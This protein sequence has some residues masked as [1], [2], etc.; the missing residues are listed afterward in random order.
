MMTWAS[1]RT[2]SK[3]CRT[4]TP[5]SEKIS[6]TSVVGPTSVTRAPSLVSA[7]TLE[8]ATRLK[9]MS[10]QI[11]TW[12]SFHLRLSPSRSRMVKASS[13]AW[14]GCSCAP[15]PALTMWALSR[16]AR[17]CG[18]PAAEWRRMTKS[19]FIASSTW[20]VS[21]SVSPLRKELDAL[22][23]ETTSA[24]RRVA[25]SSN[26]LLA[27][28]RTDAAPLVRR[29]LD[30]LGVDHLFHHRKVFG[31]SSI[32]SR[33]AT[34]MDGR[35]SLLQH[36]G[37]F[38]FS[39][40]V[41]SCL[42]KHFKLRRIELFAARTKDFSHQQIDPLPQQGVFRFQ[43]GD[44]LVASFKLGGLPLDDLQKLLFTLVFHSLY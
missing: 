7:Q 41:F 13:S 12:R 6:G 20:P 43:P 23:M 16:S 8:R 42:Q 34:T 11:T 37:G 24:S 18:A 35:V 29:A 3:S 27:Y 14:V 30:L 17:N 22:S 32:R 31:Q 19:A 5:S 15:S 10:P 26:E 28:F 2:E 40:R 25:A 36:G 9:R 4:V 21:L 39:R 1:G 38:R 33:Y 44:D